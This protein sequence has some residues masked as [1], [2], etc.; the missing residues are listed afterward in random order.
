MQSFKA[1]LSE[2]E[3]IT[4]FHG[5]DQQISSFTGVV[6]FTPRG[7]RSYGVWAWQG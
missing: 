1:F 2:S 4:C 3:A 6:F 5:T 7:R